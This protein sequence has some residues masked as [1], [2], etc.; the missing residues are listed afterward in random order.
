MTDAELIAVIPVVRRV[1]RSK[2]PRGYA[3]DVEQ[4]ALLNLIR[5]C[6]GRK[7]DNISAYAATTTVME[8]IKWFKKINRT[9][10]FLD[11]NEPTPLK[12]S[13]TINPTAKILADELL[14]SLKNP[15]YRVA[16]EKLMNG[17]STELIC[18]TERVHRFRGLKAMR[19]VAGV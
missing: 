3:E 2:A 4:A 14:G 6:N 15:T 12:L 7:I 16:C 9:A 17:D 13:Y 18:P 1:A 8:S 11:Y 10:Q 5:M 19:K